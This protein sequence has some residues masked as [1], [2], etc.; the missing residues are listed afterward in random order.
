VVEL[1][2]ISYGLFDSTRGNADIAKKNY[3]DSPAEQW[4]ARSFGDELPKLRDDL[5]KRKNE[6]E[7][8]VERHYKAW[9][10]LK[11]WKVDSDND[12]KERADP[13]KG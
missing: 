11:N 8:F 12:F 7:G 2:E 13:Y 6:G 10:N 9:K 4:V 3:P 1:P 5:I